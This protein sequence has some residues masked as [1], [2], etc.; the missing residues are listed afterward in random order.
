[1]DV[2]I[3]NKAQNMMKPILF[4]AI[5]VML[6]L[7]GCSTI[8][9]KEMQIAQSILDAEAQSAETV[10][11]KYITMSTWQRQFGG[12]ASRAAGWAALCNTPSALPVPAGVAP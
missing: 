6:A 9:S 1:M 8:T 4:Y 3:F 10:L 2:L 11:C 12:S 7:G 5:A